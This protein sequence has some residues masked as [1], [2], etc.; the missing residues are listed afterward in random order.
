MAKYL[1]I[2]RKAVYK[3]GSGRTEEKIEVLE[4]EMTIFERINAT[5]YD[6]NVYRL[7][8]EDSL[9]WK[10]KAKEHLEKEKDKVDRALYEKL[11]KKYG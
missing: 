11:K 7:E 5:H 4:N 9:G 3:D 8:E 1:L 10:G 2:T 6:F